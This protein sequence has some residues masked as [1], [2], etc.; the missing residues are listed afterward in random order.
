MVASWLV[1]VCGGF[2]LTVTLNVPMNA[3]MLAL[4]VPNDP[5]VAQQTWAAYSQ[6]WTAYNH[7]RTGFAGF[8]LLLALFGFYG[9]ARHRQPINQR[10]ARPASPATLQSWNLPLL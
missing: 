10:S 6:E 1:Y 7:I 9:I 5:L 8:S 3:E 4:G 2:V